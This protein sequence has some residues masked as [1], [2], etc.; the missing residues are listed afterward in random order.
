MYNVKQPFDFMEQI[1]MRNKVN[2]FEKRV[3]DYKKPTSSKIFNLNK[4]F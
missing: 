3:Q 4:E 2:F 1:S